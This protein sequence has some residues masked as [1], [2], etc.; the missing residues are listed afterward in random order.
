MASLTRQSANNWTVET[1]TH[2]HT[3]KLPHIITLL[4]HVISF[5]APRLWILRRRSLPPSPAA[6]LIYPSWHSCHWRFVYSSIGENLFPVF[7]YYCSFSLLTLMLLTWEHWWDTR[8]YKLFSRQLRQFLHFEVRAQAGTLLD[9][10][11]HYIHFIGAEWST[12]MFLVFLSQTNHTRSTSQH[13]TQGE[14]LKCLD[15][16]PLISSLVSS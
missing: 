7:F 10:S 13:H 4:P 14:S 6:I 5:H 15:A 9:L 12:G 1:L 11:P 8:L 2:T 16:T 3:Q